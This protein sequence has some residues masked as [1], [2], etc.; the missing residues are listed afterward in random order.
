MRNAT[1]CLAL[2]LTTL[3]CSGGATPP[4]RSE[5]VSVSGKLSKAGQ[6]VGNVVVSFHPLDDGHGRSLAVN[7]DG[8]F[9][10]ELIAGNYAYYVGPSTA[11]NSA[12]ALKKID[13]KYYEPALDR[14]IAVEAGTELVLA[15]D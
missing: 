10:G 15:L 1:L 14:S 2:A 6:P 13:P 8:T 7:P 12:V 4:L 9:L 3:G 11:P 5:P